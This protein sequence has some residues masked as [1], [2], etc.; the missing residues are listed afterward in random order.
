MYSY[1]MVR[2]GHDLGRISAADSYTMRRY[3]IACFELTSEKQLEKK[4]KEL[5]E[6]Y[7][8]GVSRHFLEL[9]ARAFF[10]TRKAERWKAKT[11]AL[12]ELYTDRGA[13]PVT[14]PPSFCGIPLDCRENGFVFRASPKRNAR[15]PRV[16]SMGP[17]KSAR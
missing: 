15:G 6:S 3:I 4:R 8:R 12:P 17:E 10:R 7:S 16:R 2:W 5:V 13:R 11:K 14:A 1:T 9:Q